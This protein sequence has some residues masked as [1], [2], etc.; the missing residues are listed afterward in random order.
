MTVSGKS[1]KLALVG[2]GGIA[3]AHWRGISEIATRARVTAVV[4]THDE[5]RAEM[6][7]RTGARAF[8]YRVASVN[9]PGALTERL[10]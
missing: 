2:C 6:A 3:Q 7:Q 1:L 4:E 9:R 8:A 10:V 5:R